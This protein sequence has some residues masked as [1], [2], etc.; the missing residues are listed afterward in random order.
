VEIGNKKKKK[1]RP[2]KKPAGNKKKTNTNAKEKKNKSKEAPNPA[3]RSI[4]YKAVYPNGIIELND[5]T[6]SKSYRIPD[7]NF[8]SLGISAQERIARQWREFLDSFRHDVNIKLSLINKTINLEQVKKKVFVPMKGDNLDKYRKEYN[9]IL[10]SKMKGARNNIET[11]KVLTITSPAKNILEADELF[12]AFDRDVADGLAIERVNESVQPM[13]IYQRLDL[14]NQIY[15]NSIEPLRQVK[16]IDGKE[17]ETFSLENCAMQGITTK[18]VI[19]PSGMKFNVNDMQIGERFAKSFYVANFPS[20][21]QGTVLTDFAMMP[22]NILVSVDFR[23]MN[24]QSALTLVRRKRINIDSIIIKRQKKGSHDGYDPTI[25]SKGAQSASNE[26]EDLIDAISQDGTKLYTVKLV[27][28]IFGDSRDELKKNENLLKNITSK[29]FVMKPLA[30][31][32]EMGF[33]TSL[34][35]GISSVLNDRLMTSD[36][37]E[38]L[39][40][41]SVQEVQ[42]P[43]GMYYG[44]NAISNNMIIYNRMLEANPAMAILG[45]PGGGKSF[46]T[47]REIVNAL[48]NSDDEIYVVDPEREYVKFAEAL[49]GTVV[50][51]ALGS[52]KHINLLDLDITVNEKDDEQIDPVKAKSDFIQ[53]VLELMLGSQS[54]SSYSLTSV[55]KSIIDT[56]VQH[57]YEPYIKHLKEIGK[58]FDADTVPTLEDLYK[59]ISLQESYEA[60]QLAIG[61][62]RFV[63][64]S[65][66]IFAKKTNIDMKSRFVVFDVSRIEGLKSVGL[67]ICFD[68]IWNRMIENYK[69]HKLTRIYI[70]EFHNLMTSESSAAYIA[71]I[72]KRA[73]KWGGIPTAITQ[74]IEDMLKSEN[75]RS[76]I[77]NSSCIM[78]LAQTDVNRI[79]LS[80][81]Y[82]ISSAE[83]EYISTSKPGMGLIRIHNKDIIPMNDDF[84]KD[85]ELY[86]IMSTK[87]KERL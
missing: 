11:V 27:A 8:R 31:Q 3:A 21:L 32:Q 12:A 9:S 86:R 39:I 18:E 67:H 60:Q 26:A 45:M 71:Q 84:P 76:V 22:A 82:S 73:R 35:I 14:L 20:W 24:Q 69:Q 57:V 23:S 6:F 44:L 75:A 33:N 87:P 36:S 49:G 2:V 78:L 52:K 15:N 5:G 30:F 17:V 81:I 37:V 19:A 51:L 48:L 40:P 7:I 13:N 68:H 42:E 62:E 83:Q 53:S 59:D 70:D 1:S 79:E 77:N 56:S 25:T 85:T 66:D 34:P 64:G 61:L 55:E 54:L 43:G 58:T 10:E 65:S 72:W 74:N 80:N 46:A 50:K 63:N 41:F 38:A 47:K 4:P 16:K 29:Y 28:T